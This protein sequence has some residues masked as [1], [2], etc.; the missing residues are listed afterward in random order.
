MVDISW[1]LIGSELFIAAVDQLLVFF[2]VQIF[3]RNVSTSIFRVT[4]W[5]RWMLKEMLERR[6]V[7]TVWEYWRKFWP[8]RAMEVEDWPKFS[9]CFPYN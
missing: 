9:S 1:N 5:F 8:V 6:N 4:V 7:S 3:Q 2:W